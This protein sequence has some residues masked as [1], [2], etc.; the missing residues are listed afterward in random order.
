MCDYSLH[1]IRNRLAV[2]GEQLFLHTFRTGSKG[3][4]SVNDLKRLQYQT[5]VPAG[6]GVWT[7]FRAWLNQK[8]R[9]MDYDSEK[10]LCAV[11]IPPGAQLQVD[12]ISP[13]LQKQFG[14]GPSEEVVFFQLS[15]EPYQYR[16]AICFSNGH[17]VLLQKLDEGLQL[18]VLCLSLPEE[19]PVRQRARA[20]T[21]LGEQVSVR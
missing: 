12:G 20:A 7:K 4:A 16:D 19:K 10:A 17:T 9:W 13:R 18:K 3:L 6:A 5:S 15:A 2:E 21:V 14:V 1:S 11:C 8:T